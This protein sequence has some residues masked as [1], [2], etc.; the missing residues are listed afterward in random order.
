[1]Y[2]D[3]NV[4]FYWGGKRKNCTEACAWNS[5]SL[6]FV[7]ERPSCQARLISARD[8]AERGALWLFVISSVTGCRG[9]IYRYIRGRGMG[10]KIN[11]FAHTYT[12]ASSSCVLFPRGFPIL[13]LLVTHS[14]GH[15][16]SETRF[17]ESGNLYNRSRCAGLTAKFAVFTEARYAHTRRTSAHSLRAITEVYALLG[18]LSSRR[19]DSLDGLTAGNGRCVF[20][21]TPLTH[22]TFREYRRGISRG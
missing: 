11:A 3:T 5:D 17:T 16:R 14:R 4:V 1:M 2:L 19:S 10:L 7:R 6:I 9:S 18:G 12:R 21:I 8:C 15:R 20:L 13:A 22:L